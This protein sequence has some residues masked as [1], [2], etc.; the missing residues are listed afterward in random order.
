MLFGAPLRHCLDKQTDDWVAGDPKSSMYMD[1]VLSGVGDDEDA[2]HYYH[3]SQQLLAKAGMN[4]RQLTTNSSKLKEK[5]VTENTIA[6]DKPK[7]LGLEW[8][9]NPNTI[10]FP[11]MK[12]VSETKALHN[13]LTKKSILSIAAKKFDP[14]LEPFTVI[15]NMMLQELQKQKVSWESQLP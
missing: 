6:N 1:N 4:L 15:A 9:S 8:D 5:L 3:H 14:L 13:Q 10:S 7:V 2:K 12:V 11:L